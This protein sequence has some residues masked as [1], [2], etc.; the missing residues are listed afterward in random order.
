MSERNKGN[1]VSRQSQCWIEDALLQLMQRE[2]YEEITIKEIAANAG[3]SRRSFY[4]N[5]NSKDQ[6]IESYFSKIWKEYVEGIRKQQNLSLPNVAYVFFETMSRHIE[7]LELIQ[8]QNLFGILLKATDIMILEPF[9]E[10]KGSNLQ[11]SKEC[12][13]YALAFSTGGFLR[14]MEKW[15]QDKPH[16]KPEAMAEIVAKFLAIA[17]YQEIR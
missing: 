3:L 14:I 8:Q 1:T 16:K 9:Y 15:I 17:S 11:E 10:M 2:K 12:I 13:D 4:R 6:V 5:F 7:F